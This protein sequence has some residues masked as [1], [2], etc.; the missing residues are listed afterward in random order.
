LSRIAHA[1]IQAD[2]AELLFGDGGGQT[3]HCVF[4]AT[5]I[6]DRGPHYPR[7]GWYE[8]WQYVQ[9]VNLLWIFDNSDRFP[10]RF[11]GML[12]KIEGNYYGVRY[13]PSHCGFSCIE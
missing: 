10:Q 11:Y 2:F 9:H 12:G 5:A 7:L 4:D 6:V 3:L 13:S 8:E 1:D